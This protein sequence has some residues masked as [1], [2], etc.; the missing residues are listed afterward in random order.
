M[1]IRIKNILY[2]TDFSENAKHAFPFALKLAK[3]TG[4]TIH[5][6]HSIE[7]PY[8]F[9]PMVEE[10]K[11]NV[12]NKVK[13][14]YNEMLEDVEKQEEY[15]EGKVKIKTHI[16]NGRAVYSIL[17]TAE[18]YNV[19]LIIMGTQGRSALEQL[20]FGST[21]SE[22]V[23]QAKVPLLAIPEDADHSDFTKIL[24][25]TDYGN[26]DLEALKLVVGYAELFGAS[27]KVMHMVRTK[28]TQEKNDLL[29]RG[30]KDKVQEHIKYKKLTFELNT[31]ESLL[32]SVNA[33]V[34]KDHI[35]LVA[36]VRY[37]PLFSMIG[38][39][40]AKEMSQSIKIPLLVI[41]AA[42]ESSKSN[43]IL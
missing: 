36:M 9:A 6:M 1:D 27:I 7:E 37:H 21:T 39:K 18:N 38:K 32:E 43:V 12:T 2:P 33:K 10:I 31:S 20:F 41:P 25:T 8:D 14:L 42:M 19:D 4:A 11:K 34:K 24:F 30:F 15:G 35:S 17:S 40:H 23:Q 16:F 5:V 29:F 13:K 22:V 26:H 28:E 3:E